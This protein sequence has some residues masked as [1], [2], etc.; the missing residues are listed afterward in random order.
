VAGP[1]AARRSARD[2][3][4][5]ATATAMVRP[6][7]VR[8][9]A[10][11]RPPASAPVPA[12]LRARLPVPQRPALRPTRRVQRFRRLRPRPHRP[13]RVRCRRRRVRPGPP[14]PVPVPPVVVPRAPRPPVAPRAAAPRVRVPGRRCRTPRSRRPGV[15]RLAV[16]RPV[17]TSVKVTSAPLAVSVRVAARVRVDRAMPPVLAPGRVTTRS[18]RRRPAWDRLRPLP[19]VPVPRPRRARVARVPARPPAA[20]PDPVPAARRALGPAAVATVARDRVA[21]VLAVPGPAR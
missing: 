20:V 7:R 19:A 10:C 12:R 17:V 2:R 15:T 6:V 21:P 18:A 8:D 3:A 13:R 14:R 16:T 5:T 11:R 1:T 4:P 9:Q